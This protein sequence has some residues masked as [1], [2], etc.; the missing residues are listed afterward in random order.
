MST[1][2]SIII[3]CYNVASWV[4]AALDS[5]LAQTYGDYEAICV[6]DGSKDETGGILDEYAA[7]DSRIKVIHQENRG[8]GGARSAGLK[9]ARGEWLVY[10]DADD[11]WHPKFL[12]SMVEGMQ[13]CPDAQI[14]K[15]KSISFE[16]GEEPEWIESEKSS[17]KILDYSNDLTSEVYNE[18]I[19]CWAY[20]RSAVGDIMF[21]KG[22]VVGED[23]AYVGAVIA[24]TTK[25][26]TLDVP[27]YGYRQRSSSA[28]HAKLSARKLSDE[29]RWRKYQAELWCQESR[30]MDTKEVRFYAACLLEFIGLDYFRLAREERKAVFPILINAIRQFL[31][32]KQIPAWYRFAM[33]V[34]CTLSCELSVFV[35]GAI[36]QWL[37]I[38]GLHR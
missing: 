1:K 37:K 19:W 34:V 11:V 7:I 9:V 29:I 17:Y 23:R 36:P 4:R 25:S 28:A 2:F 27:R 16:D 15:V 22:F 35:L 26:I 33:S 6:D 20:L 31:K 18:G 10:L 38:K 30:K 14:V 13:L 21:D 12:E 24:R 8:E 3:P 32:I 5:V